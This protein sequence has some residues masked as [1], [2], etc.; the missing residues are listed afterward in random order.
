M[1]KQILLSIA[2]L[3]GCNSIQLNAAGE[4]ANGLAPW[5]EV[6]L[7]V[8]QLSGGFYVY[9]KLNTMESAKK[10]RPPSSF[11]DGYD[12]IFTNTLLALL[13]VSFVNNKGHALKYAKRIGLFSAL[14]MATHT[15]ADSETVTRGF[16]KVPY[17]GAMLTD[18]VDESGKE[19]VEPIRL[20]N[21]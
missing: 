6:G 19:V 16:R 18:A 20:P 11:K 14:L 21:R 13:A 2:L 9:N 17:G 12:K 10:Q 4:N 5:I 7:A 3:A 15:I 1:K 8:A